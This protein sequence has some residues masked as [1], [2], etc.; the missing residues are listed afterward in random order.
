MFD[1]TKESLLDLLRSIRDGRTQLPDFQRGWVWDDEHLR[2]LLA[3][4]SMSYPIGAVMMLQTGNPDVRFKPRA[5]EGAPP[6]GP[7]GPERLILDGQQRLTSL[8]QALFMGQAVLTKDAR[9]KPIRR[10]YYVDIRRAL[11]ADADREEAVIGLPEDRVLRNFRG[12]PLPGKDY[13]TTELE[14]AAELLPLPLVFDVGRLTDWQMK[15]LQADTAR[16]TER[17]ARWNEL[18]QEVIQRFQ[19]Y[20]VPLI[21]LRKETPK[22]AVCQ[23]FEK[24]NTGGVSLTVFELLTATF[25]ADDYNLREDWAARERRLRHRPALRSS[26]NTDFLQAITLLATRDRRLDALKGG[27]P[28][29]NA[30]GISCKRRDVLRLTLADYQKWADRVTDGF[31]RAA[32]FLSSLKIYDARDVPYRTQLVPLA[33]IL[34]ALGDRADDDGVRDKVAR[35]YW[36]GVFGELYGGAI[37]TRFAKDLPDVLGWLGGG[38]EPATVADASFT[39]ARLLTLRTRNSA[40][41]KGLYALLMRD[42]GLDFR[43]GYPIDIQLYFDEKIDVHH[44]FPQKWCKDHGVEPR[45]C[46]SIVNKTPIAARTNRSIGGNAPSAYLPRV[47]KGANIKPDRMDEILR[48]HVID[49]RALRADDFD[50]FFEVRTRA[51]L[52]RIAEAMGKPIARE[53]AEAESPEVVDYEAE[54]VGA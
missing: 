28:P 19:Q 1:S 53:T 4:V 52:E 29:D 9:D 18:V 34:A 54:E 47:E 31:D 20:Q 26:E 15:Y 39:P 11:D 35:W 24:V 51:L 12:E 45:R 33:A 50:A 41:Y 23:V 2:S 38:A 27:T 48:S 5:V 22:E 46:D 7:A 30:P 8:Y 49:P 21:L 36:C 14:C 44:I 13:S 25:A 17:L 16:I 43:T 37:E 32:K 3:S 40:A 42:G 10:W 6:G